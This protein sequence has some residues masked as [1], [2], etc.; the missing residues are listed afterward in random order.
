MTGLPGNT[1]QAKFTLEPTDDRCKLF[2]DVP[3]I[4]V[5]TMAE[6]RGGGL[7]P[8]W[9][10]VQRRPDCNSFTPGND[11]FFRHAACGEEGNNRFFGSI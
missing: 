3:V 10:Y 1:N 9:F 7:H 2:I 6:I 5:M 4:R 11:D 8:D